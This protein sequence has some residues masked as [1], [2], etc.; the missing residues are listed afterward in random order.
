MQDPTS[1]AAGQLEDALHETQQ[2]T[3]SVKEAAEELAVIH[4]VLS[5]ELKA[6]VLAG[7]AGAAV[8][9][10]KSIEKQLT[11]S[12]HLLDQAKKKLQRE[13]DGRRR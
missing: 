1:P 2:A 8:E 3:E 5:S 9:Q 13:V 7:D 6:E 11:D 10:T 12:A 4:S